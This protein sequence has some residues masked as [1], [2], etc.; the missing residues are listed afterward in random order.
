MRRFESKIILVVALLIFA[1]ASASTLT[2]RT[3][4]AT[5]YRSLTYKGQIKFSYENVL[6]QIQTATGTA[7]ITFTI[8]LDQ[9]RSGSPGDIE[10]RVRAQGTFTG[11]YPG[12]PGS[13]RGCTSPITITATFTTDVRAWTTIATD[14]INLRGDGFLS[15]YQYT[16][17]G[18]SHCYTD[19]RAEIG[20]ILSDCFGGSSGR[21]T[22][23]A[24]REFPI[25]GG[26]NS[27]TRGTS[28][29]L[30]A[31]SGSASLE[32]TDSKK[33]TTPT[34]TSVTCSPS[35]MTA[36]SPTT[37]TAT[38]TGSSPTG[39]IRWSASGNGTF[40]SSTCTLSSGGCSVT[41]TPSSP[42]A[43]TITGTYGGDS[44]NDV[45]SGTVVIIVA[46]TVCTKP[47]FAIQLVGVRTTPSVTTYVNAIN[48]T[49]TFFIDGSFF[50]TATP[51]VPPECR[52]SLEVRVTVT[53]TGAD[54][55]PFQYNA[56][57][58]SSIGT[59]P[60]SDTPTT[61][62]TLAPPSPPTQRALGIWQ[63]LARA[64]VTL[65]NADPA[66]DLYGVRTY[67]PYFSDV[68]PFMVQT[69][70]PTGRVQAALA[71][72]RLAN[73][74]TYGSIT[75]SIQGALQFLPETGL[76]TLRFN[77]TGASGTSGHMTLV[78]PK[79]MVGFGLSPAVIVNG[80]RF[81]FAGP[82]IGSPGVTGPPLPFTT[83]VFWQDSTT[84]Y[85][86]INIVFKSTANV[87]VDFALPS[88]TNGQPASL[89]I[90]Q[91]GFAA[92]ISSAGPNGLNTPR[93]P[94]FDSSGNL[95]VV[96]EGNSRIL[97]F[98]P[99]FSNH[100]SASMVIGQPNFSSNSSST[101]QRGL[102]LPF[103]IA[104]DSAGN[105]WVA[106]T[107]NHRVL[108]FTAPLANGMA[109]SVVIGQTDFSTNLIA[110]TANS[111]VYPT[112]VA[113]DSSGGLWVSD[114]SNSRVLRFTPPFTNGMAAS[115]VIGHQDYT[116]YAFGTAPNKFAYP[117]GVTFDAS[118]S[119]WV[120]DSN[121]NRTLGFVPPFKIG[122]NASLVIGRSS[123]TES[124]NC[125]VS[126]SSICFPD[127]IAFDSSGNLWVA[128]GLNGR[129]LGFAP[130][131]ATGMKA[132][133]VLGQQ[134]FESIGG[135][136]SENKMWPTTLTFDQ[137]GNLWVGDTVNSRILKFASSI[138]AAPALFRFPAEFE[139]HKFAVGILS[140]SSISLF[141]FS[142]P[143]KQI[144]FRA[145]G[146]SGTNGFAEV[147]IPVGLLGGK[148]TVQ[149]DGQTKSF[150]ESSNSTHTRTRIEYP[151][152]K[153]IT[154]TGTSVIP[155][156]P[157]S[158]LIVFFAALVM[159]VLSRQMIRKASNSRH[160]T[161]S[162]RATV[163]SQGQ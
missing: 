13:E 94:V 111:L 3:E 153:V 87:E 125:V 158:V 14:K 26:S 46:V 40:S 147:A 118:G 5:S 93:S 127:G 135:G 65:S 136:T 105:L 89:V 117:V 24:C 30:R 129:I 59:Q 28:A 145:G 86:R 151:H 95:W 78:I 90:G 2:G 21:Y 4:A 62:I 96:D 58:L 56:P 43:I 139:Q 75:G 159:V 154:I 36:G 29:F 11:T 9:P 35:S 104:F 34:S 141:E 49:D 64:D 112:G 157:Q 126:Q 76:P 80:I 91:G 47:Q 160:S 50:Q 107:Y 99:P 131:F 54:G 15:N 18:P 88:F 115:L 27:I 77:V 92:Q 45:S 161:F 71:D 114:F 149:V 138:G 12:N 152:S 142:Q 19:Q 38:V 7:E 134:D 8:T 82:Q 108:Q 140:N 156:F 67:G 106:D 81:P 163:N 103:A 69:R 133:F 1:T 144:T 25:Q 20:N 84:Y 10:G 60:I 132:S 39:S 162:A 121:N 41:F 57:V 120:T 61:W 17:N 72:G 119:L 98:K 109:A 146:R 44:N 130:P 63:A 32:L 73:I 66:S 128:D 53:I 102:S 16:A 79:V 37:C 52:Y 110:T 122:M 33:S 23:Q 100:M 85:I 48:D 101:S 55:I 124:S 143:N 97:G 83:A 150:E 148:L 137:T 123:F 74:Q 155:E 6:N 22:N 42:G 113:I 51:L 70:E 116:S 31:T 68:M